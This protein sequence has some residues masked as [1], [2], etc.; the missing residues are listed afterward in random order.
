MMVDQFTKW[1]EWV[2]LP[3]QT[4]EETARAAVDHFF[5]RFGFPLQ[6]KNPVD[7]PLE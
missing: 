7:I 3:T 1:V 2:P 4:A 6:V 5:S